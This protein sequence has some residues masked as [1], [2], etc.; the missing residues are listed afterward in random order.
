MILG[1]NFLFFLFFG[2]ELVAKRKFPVIRVEQCVY[3]NLRLYCHGNKLFFFFWG[4]E[5]FKNKTKI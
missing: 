4:G 5:V 1:C 3:L 2:E